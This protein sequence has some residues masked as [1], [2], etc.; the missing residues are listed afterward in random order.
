MKVRGERGRKKV[1]GRRRKAKGSEVQ[2]SKVQGSMFKVQ[3]SDDRCQT[4][5][6][7]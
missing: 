1:K 6:V 5:E 4:A 3:V 2:G 7:R